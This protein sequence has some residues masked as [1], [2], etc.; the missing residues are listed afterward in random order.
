MTAWLERITATPEAMA[1]FQRERVL[2]DATE[3]VFE[4]MQAAGVSRRDLAAR[5]GRSKRY[6]AD[7]LKG[8]KSPSL[9]V[10]SDMF[11]ALGAELHL[12]A[13]HAQP[14]RDP[15]CGK[16]S[17]GATLV[18][19]LERNGLIGAWKDREDIDDGSEFA[20]K[21]RRATQE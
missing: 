13:T 15:G 4:L 10:L 8:R 21:L 11:C 12:R 9:A 2:L 20:A 14:L 18:A 3:A 7:F 1:S 5:I 6:V 19:A 16:P 17:D